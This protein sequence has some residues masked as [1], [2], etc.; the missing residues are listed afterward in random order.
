MASFLQSPRKHS[1][2]ARLTPITSQESNI[3]NNTGSTS[4]IIRKLVDMKYKDES[5]LKISIIDCFFFHV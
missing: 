4:K 2:K 5:Q 1:I 3:H